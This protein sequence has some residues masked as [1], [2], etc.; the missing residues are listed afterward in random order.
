MGMEKTKSHY[1]GKIMAAVEDGR[2]I[3]LVTHFAGDSCERILDVTVASILAHYDRPELQGMLY[4]CLKELVINATK[5]NAKRIFFESEG[6]SLEDPHEYQIGMAKMK[7]QLSENWVKHYGNLARAAGLSVR[8]VFR[9]S[10]AGLHVEVLN[11]VRLIPLDEARIRRKMQM[12]AGYDDLISFYSDHA[13]QLEGEGM[14]L[15]MIMLLLKAENIDPA[16]FRV[17]LNQGSTMARLEIPFGPGF[18]SVRG[19]NPHGRP[20]P[21]LLN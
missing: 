1:L 7:S 17:G 15:A 19:Q 21:A 4:T 10:N 14:G 2:T 6:L 16:L 18:V 9:H 11:N 12:A 20:N 13:D 3:V 8:M 5:T